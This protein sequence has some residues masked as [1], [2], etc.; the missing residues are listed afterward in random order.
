MIKKTSASAKFYKIFFLLF[1]GASLACTG[2][3]SK[4]SLTQ[5]DSLFQEQKY[6]E[7]FEIYSRLFDQEGV[8][9]ESMLLKMAFIQEGLGDYSSALYYLNVHFNETLDKNTFSKINQLAEEHQ[10]SGYDYENESYF[11]NV[12]KKYLWAPFYVLAFILFIGLIISTKKASKGEGKLALIIIL[13]LLA[14]LIIAFNMD[15]IQDRAIVIN[16]TT[17]LMDGPSGAANVVKT[18]SKGHQLQIKQYDEVWSSVVWQEKE[19]Y[20]RHDKLK[21]I[22]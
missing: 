20:V 1:F 17:H 6:T 14:P 21:K 10:L 7:S 19:Y 12:V 2:A 9:S 18:I 13:I 22:I 3:T 15:F 8:F 16:E 5:A 4:Q 11:S